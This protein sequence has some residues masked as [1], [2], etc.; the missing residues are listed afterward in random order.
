MGEETIE[1]EVVG[2]RGG[3]GMA[4]V[5]GGRCD[6]EE[7]RAEEREEIGEERKEEERER[8][9]GEIVELAL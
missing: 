9:G 5:G 8:I 1:M 6:G 2:E 7:E 3:I 4:V